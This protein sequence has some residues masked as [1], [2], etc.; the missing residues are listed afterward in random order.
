MIR[1]NFIDVIVQLYN[2]DNTILE[3]DNKLSQRI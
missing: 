2:K 1:T 3:I